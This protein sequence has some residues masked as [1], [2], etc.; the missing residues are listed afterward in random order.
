MSRS[1]CGF[2]VHQPFLLSFPFLPPLRFLLGIRIRPHEHLSSWPPSIPPISLSLSLS[3]FPPS[4]AELGTVAP[5]SC[6]QD[7]QLSLCSISGNMYT[8]CTNWMIRRKLNHFAFRGQS[9]TIPFYSPSQPSKKRHLL[10]I[11]SIRSVVDYYS[12]RGLNENAQRRI[13]SVRGRSATDLWRVKFDCFW[14]V[15]LGWIRRRGDGTGG[16]M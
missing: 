6:T 11:I 8:V 12:G 14:G 10:N 15:T 2:H 4:E 3:L 9:Y 13:S 16:E 1:P 7:P 5:A